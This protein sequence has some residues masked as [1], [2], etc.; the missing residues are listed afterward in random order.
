LVEFIPIAKCRSRG[1]AKYELFSLKSEHGKAHDYL[2]GLKAELT[3][4]HGIYVFFDS[5][6]QAIYAGKA[7]K[8]SLWREITGAFNRDRGSV[9]KIRRVRHP[10][11]NQAYRTNDEKARQIGEH[12]VPLFE[13]A[14]YFSAYAVAD[15]IIEDLESLLVRS[16]ANDLL[17]KRMERFGRQR[18]AKKKRKRLNRRSKKHRH[19]ARRQRNRS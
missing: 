5:R 4:H 9:Q 15:P 19:K 17:N 18:G 2:T 14:A 12:E 1:G 8:Q 16:F 13:L 6:G 10:S 7:R 3:K 11:R